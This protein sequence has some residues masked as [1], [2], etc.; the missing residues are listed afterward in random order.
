[1][2]KICLLAF[3]LLIFLAPINT[4]LAKESYILEVSSQAAERVNYELPY[5]GLLP[6]S[7]IYFLR[8]IRD[9]MVGFL[10]SDPLKKSEFDLLQADKRLNAGIS[11]FKKGK[12]ELGISTISKAENYFEESLEKAKKAHSEGMDIQEIK[13]KLID[14]SKKHLE[15]LGFLEK[16]APRNFKAILVSLLKRV[17]VFETRSN[18]L[19]LKE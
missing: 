9:R 16:K 5:S 12:I 11:L 15:E 19:G 17:E 8:I 10:I 4:S 1:M 2:K 13:R 3:S 14:S 6:D 18:S 7:P